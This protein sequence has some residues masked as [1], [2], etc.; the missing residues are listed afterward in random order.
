MPL[1]ARLQPHHRVF[2]SFAI[3]AFGLGQIFPR[4]PDVKAAMGIAEGMLGLALIGAPV[5]TL[6]ALT[7]SAPLIARIGHRKMLLSL[8]PLLS[9][10]YAIAIHATG[11][12]MLFL[13]LIPAGLAIGT[14]EVIVNIEAD[15]TEAAMGRRIMNRAHAF[16]SIGFFGAGIFGAA[17]AQ[18]GVTPQSHLSGAVILVALATWL[19]MAEFQPAAKRGSDTHDTTP[20]IARPSLAVMVLVGVTLSAM[21]LEGAAIDWS[22]IY[23]NTV[24]DTLP[25]MGGLAVAT[26]ALSQAIVRYFADSYVERFAPV[27]VARAMQALMALGVLLVFFA[28][29]AG[30]AL[31]GF[32]CIGAGTSVMFPL[33][34][35]A[36]AQRDDRPAAINVAALAQFSFVAFLL[37]PPLLGFVA[38]H[39]G[40]R[41]TFGLGLPL[42][43]FSF[44]LSGAL[45]SKPPKSA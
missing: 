9:V 20:L 27:G 7:L 18:F 10:I 25:L 23:M 31:I 44:I 39:L 36:A 45:A 29:T 2:A 21:L 24:F 37:G 28:P 43:I 41:W 14:I 15:R 22:A 4:L 35:S 17:M 6:I 12:L 19:F 42:I 32:G 30:V 3:Y 33:A 40:L 16:W 26:A 5:G 8:L 11:P 34:M 1:S 38:E 13:L